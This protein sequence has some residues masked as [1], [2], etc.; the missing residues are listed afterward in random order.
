MKKEIEEW[1]KKDS[2]SVIKEILKENYFEK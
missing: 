1:L 2:I